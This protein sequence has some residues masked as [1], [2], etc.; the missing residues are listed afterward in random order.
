MKI[1]SYIPDFKNARDWKILTICI[2]TIILNVVMFR[3]LGYYI[4]YVYPLILLVSSIILPT[5][6][7]KYGFFYN[8]LLVIGLYFATCYSLS[9]WD[10]NPIVPIVLIVL[11]LLISLGI[12][13]SSAYCTTKNKLG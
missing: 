10:V 5:V 13:V 4:A 6:F 1:Q 9:I 12:T 11:P 7:K 8:T 2:L 3:Y